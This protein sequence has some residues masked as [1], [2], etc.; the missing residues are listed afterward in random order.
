MEKMRHGLL[1]CFLTWSG[2]ADLPLEFLYLHSTEAPD[3]LSMGKF[4]ALKCSFENC[5][6]TF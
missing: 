5:F 4:I 2:G 6:A 1:Q 3:S